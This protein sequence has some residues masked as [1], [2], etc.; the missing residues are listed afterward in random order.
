MKRVNKIRTLDFGTVVVVNRNRIVTSC[1]VL[2]ATIETSN[3]EWY[4]LYAL[5]DHYGVIVAVYSGQD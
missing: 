2:V 3:G 5:A 1:D 4:D